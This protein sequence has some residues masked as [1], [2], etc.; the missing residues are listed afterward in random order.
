MAT[1]KVYPLTGTLNDKLNEQKINLEVRTSTISKVPT[2]YLFGQEIYA[3]FDE[4]SVSNEDKLVL[5]SIIANHDGNE[6]E[7]SPHLIEMREGKIRN[8]VQM[9]FNHPSL[10]KKITNDYLTKID[11]AINAFVR[12]GVTDTL[13]NLIIADSAT[14]QPFSDFLNLVVNEHGHKTFQFFISMIKS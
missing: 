12:G 10:D 1:I 4:D 14:G 2:I 5:D 11:N 3:R 6:A 9:A 13:E 7:T 8:L